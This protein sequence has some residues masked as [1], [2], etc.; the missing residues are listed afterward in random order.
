MS[1]DASPT[2]EQSRLAETPLQPFSPRLAPCLALHKAVSWLLV[3]LALTWMP[4][5]ESEL[6]AWRVWLVAGAAGLG[7]LGVALAWCEA[8]RR[9]YALRE[10]ALVQRRGLLVQRLQA[11]PL[12]RL[13]HIETRSNPLERC[14]GLVRLACFT[15]GGRSADVVLEG[16]S[17]ASADALK[18]QLLARLHANAEETSA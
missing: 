18:Q 4:L 16:L 5:G 6:L 17:P 12:A 9:A 8:R 11:L 3:V 14:F 2:V 1:Q 10:H 7:A 13:Q 15:A